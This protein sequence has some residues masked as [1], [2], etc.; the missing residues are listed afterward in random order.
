MKSKI[1]FKI[2]ICN[3]MILCCLI[4]VIILGQYLLKKII[5]DFS[6]INGYEK[7]IIVFAIMIVFVFF[8][9]IVHEIYKFFNRD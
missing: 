5:P 6:K 1:D 7:T 9:M 4:I 2:L 8:S 3:I